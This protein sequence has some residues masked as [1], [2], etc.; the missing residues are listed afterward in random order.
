M[1]REPVGKAQKQPRCWGGLKQLATLT[2]V[3]VAFHGKMPQNTTPRT[4]AEQ[5]HSHTS[6]THRLTILSVQGCQVLFII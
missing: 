6:P 3:M 5:L 1:L 4:H 2:I